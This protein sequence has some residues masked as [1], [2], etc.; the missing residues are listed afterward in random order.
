[1]MKLYKLSF[2]L[3][4]TFPNI[5]TAQTT[6]GTLVSTFRCDQVAKRELFGDIIEAGLFTE[7]EDGIE[8]F[9]FSQNSGRVALKMVSNKIG[10]EKIVDAAYFKSDWPYM[11]KLISHI[12]DNGLIVVFHV[13]VE[14]VKE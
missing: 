14:V 7:V 5:V 11:A 9:E 4:L 2:L 12:D 10:C 1:M 8:E 3:A 13:P 6:D